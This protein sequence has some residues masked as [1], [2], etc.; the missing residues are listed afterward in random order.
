M[1][2][3]E[4]EGIPMSVIQQL[5]DSG[6]F[7][8]KIPQNRPVY[9]G[10]VCFQLIGEEYGESIY[11]TDEGNFQI[12]E[13]P[14]NL[15]KFPNNDRL[16]AFVSANSFGMTSNNAHAFMINDCHIGEV[17]DIIRGRTG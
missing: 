17:I 15:G 10:T 16:Y 8:E 3:V 9:R 4:K 2:H 13:N 14:L 7:N 1:R 12:R 6:L 5:R 11:A